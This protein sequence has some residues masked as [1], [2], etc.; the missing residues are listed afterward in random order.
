MGWFQMLLIDAPLII[1]SFW[2]LSA[3]YVMAQT[4]LDA[5]RWKRAVLM[6][7]FLMAAGVALTISN[8][9][10][11]MEA[12]FGVQTGFVRTPKFAI[13]DQK[14]KMANTQY[15]RGS[16]WLPYLEIAAGTYFLGMVAFAI[17]TY[18]FLS[19]PFLMLFVCGYFWAGFSTVYQEFQGKLRWKAQMAE[20]RRAAEN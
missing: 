13:G 11:V 19:I 17:D 20:A 6:L 14:V 1:A 4:E 3:F 5:K 2:S 15:R 16:G 9:R 7:P 12:L 18:N 8:T 10:A